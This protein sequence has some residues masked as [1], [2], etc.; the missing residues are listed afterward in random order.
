MIIRQTTKFLN[1]EIGK[2]VITSRAYTR[3][4]P[5]ALLKR[6]NG[7]HSYKTKQIDVSAKM[8]EDIR[9]VIAN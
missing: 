7:T 3:Y 1:E 6:T 8:P 9:V 2:N 4:L 5:N